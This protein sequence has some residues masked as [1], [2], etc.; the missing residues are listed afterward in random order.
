MA[1]SCKKGYYFCNSSQKCKRIP[2]GH[3]VQS[4]G[5]LVREYV[6]D[7]RSDLQEK[8]KKLAPSQQNLSTLADREKIQK[9]FDDR[10]LFMPKTTTKTENG[11]TTTSATMVS[12]EA[13]TKSALDK[14]GKIRGVKVELDPDGHVPNAGK[15]AADISTNEL[16]KVKPNSKISKS[17][18][19]TVKKYAS[20]GDL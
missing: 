10:P 2:R 17:D 13:E 9:G 14:V 5:E 8:Q 6:S 1:S 11:K 15:F 19:N 12:R 4:D 18:L 20:G 3:K 7:W 16:K